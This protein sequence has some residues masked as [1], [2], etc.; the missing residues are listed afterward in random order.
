MLILDCAFVFQLKLHFEHDTLDFGIDVGFQINVVI[1]IILKEE[2]I[3]INT[4]ILS[5]RVRPNPCKSLDNRSTE[6][7]KVRPP[8]V[9]NKK[10][11]VELDVGEHSYVYCVY[12]VD[13]FLGFFE[14]SLNVLKVSYILHFLNPTPPL[15]Q[16]V[17]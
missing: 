16:V 1:G 8:L 17:T 13:T 5:K 7:P 4:F 9:S 6:V 15:L 12:Y 11:R 3:G 10:Y 2:P 14:T